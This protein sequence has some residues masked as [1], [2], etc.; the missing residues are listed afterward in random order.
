MV[1]EMRGS[2][3]VLGFDSEPAENALQTAGTMEH[4][5]FP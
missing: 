4:K 1:R 3:D 5:T 2:F